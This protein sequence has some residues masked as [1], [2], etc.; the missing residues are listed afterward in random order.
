MNIDPKRLTIEQLRSYE[1]C[2]HYTEEEAGEVIDTL[3]Q[4]TIVLFKLYKKDLELKEKQ[5]RPS[6]E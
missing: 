6:K 1:G 2:E 4:L 5:S 3:E